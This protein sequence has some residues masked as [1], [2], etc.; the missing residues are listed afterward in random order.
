MNEKTKAFR[1]SAKQTPPLNSSGIDVSCLITIVFVSTGYYLTLYGIELIPDI[2]VSLQKYQNM[3]YSSAMT[4]IV[5]LS[6]VIRT[7]PIV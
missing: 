3:L 2:H 6:S 7:L 4:G 5:L 1:E